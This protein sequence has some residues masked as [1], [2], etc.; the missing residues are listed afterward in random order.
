MRGLN[1]SCALNIVTIGRNFNNGSVI[2]LDLRKLMI[3]WVPKELCVK[4]VSYY[5]QR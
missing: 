4:S 1:S 2:W 5:D 3:N